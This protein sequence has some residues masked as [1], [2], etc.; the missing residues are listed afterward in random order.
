MADGTVVLDQIWQGQVVQ[1]V[2][3]FSNFPDIEED[4]QSFTDV[5]KG[6]WVAA[7]PES[8]RDSG[9]RMNGLTFV[10]N[11]E[12]PIFSVSHEFTTGAIIGSSNSDTL[13]TT[14][15]QLVSTQRVGTPPNRGRVYFAGHVEG[16]VNAVGNFDATHVDENVALIETLRDGLDYTAN[17]AFLRIGRR[18]A[19]GSLTLTSPIDSVVGRFVPATQRRRRK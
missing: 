18:L 17:V 7:I 9:W 4:R 6:L 5:F 13:P 16:H 1:N 11:D 8:A 2:L 14:V 19:D 12:V 15:A 10:Y 3:V